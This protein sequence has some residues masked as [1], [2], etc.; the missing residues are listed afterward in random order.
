MKTFSG[1]PAKFGS[2]TLPTIAYEKALYR[3]HM[4]DKNAVFFGKLKRY[5]F[6]SPDQSYGVLYAGTSIEAA[7]AEVFLRDPPRMVAQA[8]ISERLLS[9]IYHKKLILL[10][11]YGAGLAKI[12]TTAELGTCDYAISQAWSAAIHHHPQRVDGIFWAGRHDND[13]RNV[14]IFDRAE[15]KI[16]D[17]V[18]APIQTPM[19]AN[20][21]ARYDIALV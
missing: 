5:R 6:D 8:A 16:T 17:C 4:N 10:D 7:F 15:S 13:T 18:P 3:L 12:G 2:Q 19:L 20:L 14:A 1:P 9:T 11:A 21:V